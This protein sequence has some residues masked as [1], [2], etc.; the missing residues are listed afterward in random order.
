MVREFIINGETLVT[1][2]GGAHMSGT[3]IGTVSELGLASEGIR[4]TP[5][6]FHTPINADDFGPNVSPEMQWQLAYVDID[7]TL[8]HTFVYVLDVCMAESMG[9]TTPISGAVVTSGGFSGQL[10]DGV[11]R[12]AGILNP[13]GS[14]LG[15]GCELLRSGCH[16]ISLNLTSPVLDYPWRFRASYINGQPLEIPLGTSVSMFRVNWRAIPYAPLRYGVSYRQVNSML[17]NP[18]AII[19]SGNL[20]VPT[21]G[22]LLDVQSSG[23]VLWD[24]FLDNDDDDLGND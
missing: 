5:H 1:C 20:V 24:H 10:I 12:Q 9:G 13:A 16:Y 14:L 18:T 2:K 21:S 4:I 8:I 19:V 11:M 17:D 22:V 23:I 7:M 3:L 15:N 6:Y